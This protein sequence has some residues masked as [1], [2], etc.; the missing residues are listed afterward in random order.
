[1]GKDFI[2]FF[3]FSLFVTLYLIEVWVIYNIV[4]I[5]PVQQSDSV[6]YTHMQRCIKEK[7][8]ELCAA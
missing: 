1:M 4:L 6:L 5:S 3:F 8:V 2:Y 7:N